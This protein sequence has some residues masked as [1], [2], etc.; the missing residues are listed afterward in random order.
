M[1]LVPSRPLQFQ[2]S[3]DISADDTDTL[4]G[5]S[6]THELWWDA[7]SGILNSRARHITKVPGSM[8]DKDNLLPS[9]L[10]KDETEVYYHGEEKKHEADKAIAGHNRPAAPQNRQLNDLLDCMF[11]RGDLVLS[12]F[13]RSSEAGAEAGHREAWGSCRE[14]EVEGKAR[15]NHQ[16]QALGTAILRRV[17]LLPL[18]R[19][20]SASRVLRIPIQPTNANNG[21]MPP[22]E[23]LPLS[24]SYRREPS[25]VAR[26]KSHGLSGRRDGMKQAGDVLGDVRRDCEEG[27][28]H[29]QELSSSRDMN[30]ALTQH[31]G[32]PNLDHPLALGGGGA[33]IGEAREGTGEKG[34]TSMGDG[35]VLSLNGSASPKQGVETP[36]GSLGRS[37]SADSDSAGSWD[38]KTNTVLHQSNRTEHLLPART[39]VCVRVK[40]VTLTDDF[41]GVVAL[42]RT[43]DLLV[44]LSFNFPRFEGY[45]GQGEREPGN[46]H[47][48][49]KGAVDAGGQEVHW[50]PTCA[51]S[52]EEGRDWVP[53]EWSFEVRNG[54]SYAYH[55]SRSGVA[56]FCLTSG[57]FPKNIVS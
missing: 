13:W 55:L 49:K 53:F 14:G 47:L 15:V 37:V 48:W 39:K 10:N 31:A 16:R 33:M 35:H 36:E 44:W 11:G 45:K 27:K 7:D 34:S 22:P 3:L 17:D 30:N 2:A 19:W 43:Q 51:V 29:D 26:R 6:Q 46:N 42:A 38:S 52:R 54:V 8:L 24:I 9:N 21:G 1:Y 28:E 12:L 5:T 40:G 57:S 18:V 20:A 50:S 56:C 4:C 23:A 32:K 41:P 25:A